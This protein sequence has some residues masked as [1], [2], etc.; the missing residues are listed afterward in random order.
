MA[1]ETPPPPPP[2]PP[3][4]P[5]WIVTLLTLLAATIKS[6]FLHSLI[7]ALAAS[8]GTVYFASKALPNFLPD[9]KGLLPRILPRPKKAEDAIGRIQFGNAGCTATIIGPVASDD[10]TLDILT[11][12]HCVKVGAVGKMTLKDGRVLSVK[13]VARDANSDAAW[14]VAE[15]PGGNVP[16][17]LLADGNP[18]DGEVV[19]HQG[20]GIDRP[21]NRESGL[22]K[23][24]ASGGQQVRFRLSVSPGDSGGGII[25]DS[26]SR[27]IS[28]V[29]CTTKLAATG[30]VFGASPEYVAR[31]R[32]KRGAS[33]E[34]PPLFYP[35]L[36]MPDEVGESRPSLPPP[37]GGWPAAK[38]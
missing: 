35:V 5:T 37:R 30:D 20:Y 13:C 8:F 32:P 2:P 36:P 21:G 38:N 28:P 17:L 33:D 27:V 31:L 3:P 9:G 24:A 26:D 6:P 19:W 29:C 1:V 22:F 4:I 16:Y 25:L 10:R 18:Q 14:L 23:G 34:E 12:A 15:N 7:T 11:A